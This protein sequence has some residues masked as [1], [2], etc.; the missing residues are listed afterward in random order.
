M[1]EIKKHVVPCSFYPK[2]LILILSIY[3]FT[4]LNSNINFSEVHYAVPRISITLDFEERPGKAILHECGVDSGEKNVTL[5]SLFP[6]HD[7]D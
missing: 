4:L 7:F 2:S 1:F 5:F 6:W 3:H